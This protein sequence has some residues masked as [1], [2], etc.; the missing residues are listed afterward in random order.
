MPRTRRW[1]T[2][3]SSTISSRC[4]TTRCS[5]AARWPCSDEASLLRPITFQRRD[6]SRSYTR[7]VSHSYFTL[8][9][10][11]GCAQLMHQ[12]CFLS[13]SR[14]RQVSRVALGARRKKTGTAIKKKEYTI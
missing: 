14:S 10:V 4:P 3:S 6:A 11:A 2:S 9:V 12:L 5:A 8:P 13:R 7:M 1:P